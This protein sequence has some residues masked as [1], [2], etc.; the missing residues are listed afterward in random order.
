MTRMDLSSPHDLRFLEL[1]PDGSVKAKFRISH[2]CLHTDWANLKADLRISEF[3]V[4]LNCSNRPIPVEFTDC[5]LENWLPRE[6]GYFV[7]PARI[8][9]ASAG[10]TNTAVRIFRHKGITTLHARRSRRNWYFVH[11]HGGW[12]ETDG[13]DAGTLPRNSHEAADEFDIPF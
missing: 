3:H 7:F 5:D 6:A 4:Y 11:Q 8:E 9:I 13:P 1:R 12:L 10:N 2:F